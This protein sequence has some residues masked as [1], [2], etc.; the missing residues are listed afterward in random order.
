MLPPTLIVVI[1]VPLASSVQLKFVAFTLAVVGAVGLTEGE[2]DAVMGV[3]E[4]VATVGVTL[5]LPFPFGP[6]DGLQETQPSS[7]AVVKINP[8]VL[9][10]SVPPH[11]DLLC[12][13]C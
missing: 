10:I 2:G 9:N 12:V 5:A 8:Q 3:G 6:V 13:V 1:G 4:T 7:R 11:G